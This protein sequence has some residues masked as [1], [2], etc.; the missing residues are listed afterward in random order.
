PPAR[1]GRPGH[2]YAGRHREVAPA[3]RP[4][5]IEGQLRRLG[6]A[7]Q[8]TRAIGMTQERFRRGLDDFLE[9]S[10]LATAPPRLLDDIDELVGR[11]HPKARW[12]AL[13][14]EKPMRTGRG[15]A[16][17]SPALRVASTVAAVLLF[18][19]LLVAAA[20]T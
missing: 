14:T 7:S 17:G 15:V 20:A 1:R 10:A 19:T 13:L 4:P 8:A 9:Q 16:V 6:P 5:G 2:G 12:L 11:E 18:T 3:S